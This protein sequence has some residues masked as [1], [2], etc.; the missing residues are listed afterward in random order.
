MLG[1]ENVTQKLNFEKRVVIDGQTKYI[2]VYIP[3]ARVLIEQKSSDKPLDKKYSQSD[4]SQMTPFEQAR[5]YA[6]WMKLGINIL[7][8]ILCS[9]KKLKRFLMRWRFLLRREKLLESFMINC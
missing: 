9:K 6:H 1:I 7:Y 3:E 4:G 2:D 5:N 8:L